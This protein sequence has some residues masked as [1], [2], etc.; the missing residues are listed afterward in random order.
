MKLITLTIDDYDI[1]GPSY[2][3]VVDDAELEEACHALEAAV[4][5]ASD[6]YI[7]EVQN[8]T[9][10]GNYA[11]WSEMLETLKNDVADYAADIALDPICEQCLGHGAEG[12][13]AGCGRPPF[14]GEQ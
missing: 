5:A 12:G 9:D 13:C 6:L 1:H 11:E 10:F 14:Q 8:I 4:A 2:C 7:I 3:V